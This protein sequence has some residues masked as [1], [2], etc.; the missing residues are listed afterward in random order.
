MQT[1]LS[2]ISDSP[3]D[4]YPHEASYPDNDVE[5]L[6]KLSSALYEGVDEANDSSV[7]QDNYN[8]FNRNMKAP[9]TSSKQN[10]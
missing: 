4:S 10:S 7:S 1:N 9:Y 6:A 3:N 5:Q 8:A 2:C